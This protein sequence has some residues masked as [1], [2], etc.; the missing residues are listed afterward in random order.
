LVGEIDWL[1]KQVQPLG[2]MFEGNITLLSLAELLNTNEI[3]YDPYVI[4]LGQI[5]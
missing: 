2:M 5:C 1:K 3:I 4:E